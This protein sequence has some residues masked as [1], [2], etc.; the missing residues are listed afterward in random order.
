MLLMLSEE[1]DGSL[2]G[3]ARTFNEWRCKLNM[4]LRRKAKEQHSKPKKAT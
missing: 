2:A 3:M 1:L 4:N